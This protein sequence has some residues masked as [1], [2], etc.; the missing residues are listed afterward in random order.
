MSLKE[1]FPFLIWFLVLVLLPNFGGSLIAPQI[2]LTEI[3]LSKLNFQAGD[4][5]QGSVS[6]E[7]YEEYT[8]TDLVFHFQLWSDEVEGVPTQLIDQKIGKE[9][10]ALAPGEKTTKNFEYQL[11]QNLPQ[12]DYFVF[13]VRIANTKGE[14]WGWIDKVI[15]VGGEGKFLTLEN[16]WILK[17]GEKLSPGGGVGYQPGEIPQVIFDV[18]NQSNFTISAFYKIITY[19]RNVGEVLNDVEK[20]KF[21]F[22]PKEKKTITTELPQFFKPDSYLSEIKFFDSE[23][24]QPIS[25]SV[26]FRWVI[27]G[28]EDAEILSV[29]PEKDSYS[30]G[31]SAKVKIQY[32]GPAHG[33]EEKPKEGKISIN[34]YDEEGRLIGKKEEKIKLKSG[35]KISEVPIIQSGKIAK[36]ETSIKDGD[37]IL[38]EYLQK[39]RKEKIPEVS[40]KKEVGIFEKGKII[41]PSL[42]IILIMVVVF[43]LL[44]KFK[45]LPFFLF[46]LLLLFAQ[47]VYGAT[48]VTGGCCDTTIVFNSPP[49]NQTFGPGDTIHFSGAFRVTSCGNGLFFNKVT[50]FITE[51][52]E[53]PIIDCCGD[54]LPSECSDSQQC[55]CTIGCTNCYGG[56]SSSYSSCNFKWCDDVKVLGDSVNSIGFD[57]STG[58]AKGTIG[59][60]KVYKLGTIYPS[61]VGSGAKPYEVRYDQ[62]FEVPKD[63]GFS[64]PVRFYVQY[65]GTHWNEHWHWN[66]TYQKGYICFPQA[67]NLSVDAS[68]SEICCGTTE[69]ARAKFSWKFSD[70]DNCSPQSAYRIQIDDNSDFSSPIIDT[71]KVNSQS[72]SFWLQ[73]PYPLLEWNKT[74]YWRLKVWNSKGHE[75]DWIFGPQF[76]TPSH[77]FPVV[78]FDWSPQKPTVNQVVQF[79]DKSKCYD[80]PGTTTC[81]ILT[82]DSFLWTFEK[83]NPSSSTE[84]NPTTTFSSITTSKITLKVTDSSDYSCSA[85]KALQTTYPFPLFKE[86]PPIFFKMREFLASLILKIRAF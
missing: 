60:Y 36:I 83:G 41:I 80:T 49:P 48:Q 73:P 71:G 47:S 8:M 19:K 75:S 79:I 78:D 62:N 43:Y 65:S 84:Q 28:E 33:D 66:I 56:K 63:L 61:D 44:K 55:T 82:G 3:N 59:G 11:P 51:D 38:D 13:R 9:V 12:K 50:F 25:N 7:N 17:G 31:E 37:K 10:F 42:L 32:T 20:E 74:Y 30:A 21:V 57:T 86:I 1:K 85:S 35:E 29:A 39:V 76:N 45:K 26:E 2:Y 6:L 53:I 24:K 14:E 15:Q 46:L 34:L 68:G 16:N 64:G 72:E 23:T 5:V 70:A 77:P 27:E 52:K 40:P 67:K 58:P 4:I 69:G 81:S 54:T 18:S 22:K